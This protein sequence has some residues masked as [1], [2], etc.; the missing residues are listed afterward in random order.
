MGDLGVVEM[1]LFVLSWGGCLFMHGCV[2][3]SA[4][5]DL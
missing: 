2:R 3:L 4:D 1:S 5:G